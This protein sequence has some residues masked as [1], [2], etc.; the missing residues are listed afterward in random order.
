MP[1]LQNGKTALD[2]AKLKGRTEIVAFL[3]AAMRRHT[4]AMAQLDAIRLSELQQRA[5]A[6]E[7]SGP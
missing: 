1:N 7:T 4:E 6:L 5:K 2:L 3:E